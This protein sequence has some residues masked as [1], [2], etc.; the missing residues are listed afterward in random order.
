MQILFPA[1]VLVLAWFL[2]E[3]PRWLYTRGKHAEA[4]RVLAKYHGL[5]KED[6]I[7]VSMQINE[8]EEYLNLDGA[9]RRWWDYSALFKHRASRYRLACNVC[10]TIFSQWA[11]NGAVDYFLDGVLESAGVTEQLKKMNI[12]LGK[13]CMQLTFVSSYFWFE[14]K[15]LL[16]MNRL[17]PEPS[18]S[19]GSVVA[20]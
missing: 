9:D 10:I 18:S 6:S 1:M 17:L 16:T 14:Q 12:N 3:S 11:G 20:P 13:S 7:W 15:F 2:P 4:K 19:T 5:G 8:Y